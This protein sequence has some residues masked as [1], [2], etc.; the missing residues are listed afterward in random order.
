MKT[1]FQ[2]ILNNESLKFIGKTLFYF[3]IAVIWINLFFH[4]YKY[5][6][7]TT[8]YYNEF[9]ARRYMEKV[10]NMIQTIDEWARK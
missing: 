3:F 8:T 1:T 5:I 9:E 10:I 7:P 4:H 2:K 6:K